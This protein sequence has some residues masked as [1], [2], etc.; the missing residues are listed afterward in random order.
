MQE[1]FRL[2][3]HPAEEAFLHLVRQAESSLFICT[4][5]I[6]DYGAEILLNHV[7]VQDL[8]ILTNLSLANI[9]G[10]NFDLSALLKLWR[11]YEPMQVSS[12]GK[13]HAKVYIADDRL[14]FITSANL[15]RGGLREN[16]E[17]GI[18][19]YE[20]PLVRSLREDM[21]RYFLLGNIFHRPL[22]EALAEEVN[23]L[24]SLRKKLEN[25]A[26]ARK[27]RK[28]LRE[29]EE[30]L[31][32]AILKNRV[33][34][35]SVNALFAETILFLLARYGPLSTEEMHPLIQN[36]HPD[37]CDDS[38]DRVIN[39]EHFGKK[40]KHQVRNAQQTLK[41]QAKIALVKGK[42]TLL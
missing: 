11:R 33:A 20:P 17:Y 3:A 14:A 16:Y 7:H 31:Q 23:A 5:Y 8:Y 21:Q 30:A 40:W 26:E 42:W 29:R 4:P 1:S 19:L 25:T 32:T 12:L 6:K 27:M 10:D 13:L 37:I 2:I 18:L 41:A 15:T 22:V 36:I 39:G 35:R 24:Q 28:A 38:I 9:S 34:A